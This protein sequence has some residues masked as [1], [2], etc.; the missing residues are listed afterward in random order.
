MD[1]DGASL[2][3]QLTGGN[4]GRQMA[5]VLDGELMSA[6]T[7]QAQLSSGGTI[8]GDF[9]DAEYRYLLNTLGAGSLE[10]Q[11]VLRPHQPENHRPVAGRRTTSARA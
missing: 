2:L 1:T 3:G 5:I 4:V 7:L 8:T 11:L 6:P 9:N 10:G